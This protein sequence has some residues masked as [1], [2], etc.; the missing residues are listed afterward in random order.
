MRI[1]EQ[2]RQICKLKHPRA[3]GISKPT[4]E[5]CRSRLKLWVGAVTISGKKRQWCSHPNLLN[6]RI[7]VLSHKVPNAK[8]HNAVFQTKQ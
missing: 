2:E 5:A 3:A 4:T 7:P 6:N 1:L 8:S